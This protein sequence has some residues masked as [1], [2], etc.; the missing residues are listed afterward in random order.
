[1]LA[2]SLGYP[3]RR[4]RQKTV[5]GGDFVK[6]LTTSIKTTNAKI[7]KLCKFSYPS[8]KEGV[9]AVISQLK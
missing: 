2:A 8:Y 7:S 4:L 3:M 9:Q 1:M 5:L 6:L